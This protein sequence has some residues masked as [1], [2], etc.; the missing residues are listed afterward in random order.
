MISMFLSSGKSPRKMK[1]VQFNQNDSF[2]MTTP[3]PFIR[4]LLITPLKLSVTFAFIEEPLFHKERL[5]KIVFNVLIMAGNIKMDWLN[6][7]QVFPQTK[8]HLAFL[9]SK[10]E[11]SMMIF[12]YVR[13]TT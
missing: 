4:M 13:L 9:A 6:I 11:K 3:S 10:C 12:I 5:S 2:S 7:F 8:M 1:S